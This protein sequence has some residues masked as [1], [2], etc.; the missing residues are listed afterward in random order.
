VIYAVG[1]DTAWR[2]ARPVGAVL[3]LLMI[4]LF[5]TEQ[6]A[7]YQ[8]LVPDAQR[9]RTIACLESAG[10]TAARAPYWQS[11]PITFLTR[12]R[13]IVSPADGLDRYAPYTEATQ[14]A[15]AVGEIC[16]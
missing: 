10:V 5:A 12:E 2:D 14:H 3:L 15:A 4:G 16:R 1:I 6:T 9:A 8:R 7:W 11:Y 13:I